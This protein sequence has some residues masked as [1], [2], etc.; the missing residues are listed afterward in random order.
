[1]AARVDARIT[2][3]R[4][5]DFIRELPLEA[6]I[7]THEAAVEIRNTA[8]GLSRVETGAMRD[9]W[10]FVTPLE[11]DY[12]AAKG[13]ANSKRPGSATSGKNVPHTKRDATIGN[14]VHYTP[15]HE[16]GTINMPSKP[17]LTPAVEAQRKRYPEGTAVRIRNLAGRLSR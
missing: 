5:P 13:R 15:H 10:Y 9:G 2:F 12:E 16:Y 4:L 6:D 7:A 11:D 17:A 14:V 3:N 8:S 1:M